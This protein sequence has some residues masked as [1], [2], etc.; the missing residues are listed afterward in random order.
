[1]WLIFTIVI[2]LHLLSNLDEMK[3]LILKYKIIYESEEVEQLQN[4]IF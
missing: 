3:Y 4:V 2:H 1:M